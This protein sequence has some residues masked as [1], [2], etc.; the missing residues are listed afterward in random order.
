[1][2]AEVALPIAAFA[3]SL[4]SL[5]VSGRVAWHNHFRPAKVVG[6]FPHLVIWTLSSYKGDRPTGDV[7]SRYI[8]PS[9]WLS[10][11]GAREALIEDLRLMFQPKDQ[12]PFFA[13]PISK[14]PIE[15]IESPTLF[16][17]YDRIGHGGPFSGF[18]LSRSDVWQCCFAFATK[19]T[20]YE[21]LKDHVRADIQLCYGRSRRWKTVISEH[22]EFGS[23]PIH[24][25]GLLRGNVAA[26]AMINHV[27]SASWESRRAV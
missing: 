16:N 27:F 7:A 17:Q 13:Y 9:F 26:G 10:N 18:A 15:A 4:L 2:S 1:M 3:V 6:A 8:T 23:H 21:R 14:V 22:L 11:T 5:Y 24:L 20:N 25:Q 12:E 19:M